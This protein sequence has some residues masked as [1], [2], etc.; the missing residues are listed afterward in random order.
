VSSS[1]VAGGTGTSSSS[2]RTVPQSLP[3][4]DGHG[5]THC[6]P[7]TSLITPSSILPTLAPASCSLPLHL[8]DTKRVVTKALHNGSLRWSPMVCLNH[9]KHNDTLDSSQARQRHDPRP[10]HTHTHTKALYY[11]R[12]TMR[13]ICQYGTLCIWQ[14]N[15]LIM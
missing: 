5:H 14:F 11:P 12:Y 6:Y 9:V 7:H 3:K 8:T 4:L 2:R 15:N 1:F 10:R 13:N